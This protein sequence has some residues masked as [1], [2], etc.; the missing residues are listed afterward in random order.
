SHLTHVWD[1]VDID[2]IIGFTST[3]FARSPVGGGSR[4]TPLDAPGG[5]DA[6]SR[7]RH[8]HVSAPGLPG[9]E[10]NHGDRPRGDGRRRLPGTDAAHHSTGGALASNGALGRVRRR[11][12]PVEGPARPLLLSWPDPRGDHHGS[13]PL[14]GPLLPTA[15]THPLPD[16]KQVPG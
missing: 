14:G 13:R 11:D 3:D 6:K 5:V 4:L 15:S 1:G 9:F 2:E 7:R 12:V 8:L 10:E 16:S